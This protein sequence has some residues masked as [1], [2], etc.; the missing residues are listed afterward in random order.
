MLKCAY[1]RRLSAGNRPDI[2]T[3][4]ALLA[5]DRE[6]NRISLTYGRRNRIYCPKSPTAKFPKVLGNTYGEH[7]VMVLC[8]VS[9]P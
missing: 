7:A 1:G 9:W 8:V 4:T 3:Q 6:S 2:Q 5:I